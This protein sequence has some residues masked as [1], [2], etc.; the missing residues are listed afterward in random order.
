MR[1][2]GDVDAL[3]VVA[4]LASPAGE[5]CDGV[6]DDPVARHDLE[7]G[8]VVDPA[9]DFDDEVEEGRLVD[10]LHSVAGAI[11]EQVLDPGPA[12]ADGVR[13]RLRAPPLSDMSAGVSL[14][15]SRRPS[16][17]TATYVLCSFI[18]S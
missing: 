11:G 17:S 2:F 14:T 1:V 12:L 16:V 9:H 5:L 3:F 15:I 18:S 6:F 8:L 4:H 13:G 10:E 7:A